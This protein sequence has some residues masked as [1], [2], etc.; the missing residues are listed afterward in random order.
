AKSPTNT[1]SPKSSF[2]A[3]LNP[4]TWGKLGAQTNNSNSEPSR[5]VG[6]SGLARV[7]PKDSISN[8]RD[9][10]KAWIKEQASK[11]VERYFN[12]ENVDGSNPALNV[13]Q[14]LCT[15]TEQ[16]NIQVGGGMECL[17]EISSIVS[18]SDVSS[19]EI[20]H[21]GLVKQLLVYLTSSTDRDL[22]SRDVRLKRFLRVFAGCPVPGMELS[23]RLDPSENGPYLAVVHKMNSCLSQMEQFPVKVQIFP[24]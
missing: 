17:V 3:S 21:S 24:G 1:Q 22:L 15:A 5:T 6:V 12:S 18:E 19:F 16:L 23:G 14:R 2:L 13:L 7:P 10:I 11:F 4:K 20:Q 8:N 9:K